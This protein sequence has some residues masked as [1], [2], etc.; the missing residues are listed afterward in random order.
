MRRAGVSLRLAAIGGIFG[1]TAFIGAWAIGSTIAP[2]Y[3]I[4]DDPISRLAAAGADTRPLITAGFIAFGVGVPLYATQL[5]RVLGGRASMTAAAT[6]LATIAVAAIPLDHSATADTWHGIAAAIAYVTL[7]ATPALAVRPLRE[8]GYRGLAR[9]SV[10]SSAVSASALL[11]STAGLP[12]GLFQRV[13]LTAGDTWIVAT[14]LAI[15]SGQLRS[16]RF[17]ATRCRT[18][19]HHHP[20]D[21][22]T[23][24]SAA[25]H[26]NLNLLGAGAQYRE[27]PP[28]GAAFSSRW[29]R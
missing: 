21:T 29:T 2:G 25:H 22:R 28:P 3:S 24:R 1:P 19:S 16:D 9:F 20:D 4:V 10:L 6:G 26:L 5:R 17:Y 23:T 11:L 12:N 7:A 18:T 8:Q 27:R 15:L 14:A 13:G